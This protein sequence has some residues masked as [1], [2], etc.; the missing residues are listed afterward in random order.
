MRRQAKV[1]GSNILRTLGDGLILRRA[2]LE[3]AEALADHLSLVYEEPARVRISDL[4]SGRLARLRPE[5]FTLVEDTSTGAIVS[6]LNLMP[7]VWSY[8]GLRFNVGQ[9]E[10]V[11]THPDY[12]RRGLVRAQMETVHQ[13]SAQRGEKAVC[14]NGIPWFYRQFGYELALELEGG[15]VGHPNAPP[16]GEGDT[17]PYRLRPAMEADVPFIARLYERGMERYMVSCVRDEAMWRWELHSRR[18]ESANRNEIRVIETANQEPVGFLVHSPRL[19][20]G[21]LSTKVYEL[22]RAVSWPAATP[23]VIRY[24]ENTGR[25][26]AAR[27]KKDFAA[28]GFDMGTEHPAYQAAKDRLPRVSRPY[29][30][31]VR[32]PD[33]RGLIMCIGPVLEERLA[34]SSE[35]KYT[36]GLAVSFAT[37]GLRLLFDKGRLSDV[38]AL[39]PSQI[40]PSLDGEALDALFPGLIFLQLLFGHRSAEDLLYSFADCRVFSDKARALLDLLFPKQASN[41]WGLH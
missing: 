36:D 26:Y 18:D 40:D 33:L 9:I 4:M 13:W 15:R 6:S 22:E 12:R 1:R 2:A 14:I 24:L 5:D 17:G 16:T 38:E 28:L 19:S 21:K 23:S 10:E 41:V 32:V 20:R 37:S 29:A 35:S 39:K 30:W 31:Y 27:D 7:Q 11:A 3:D 8:A 34:R 25:E